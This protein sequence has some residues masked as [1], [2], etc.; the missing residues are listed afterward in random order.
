MPWFR[1]FLGPSPRP[2]RPAALVP[3]W[4]SVDGVAGFL[5]DEAPVLDL[6][7]PQA[8]LV[9][10]VPTEGGRNVT[11]VASP[12]RE[13]NMLSVWV[14]GVPALDVSVDGRRVDGAFTR[15]APDDTAWT[16][17]YLQCTRVR[18][19]RRADAERHA[20]ADRGRGGAR[21]R[22]ARAAGHLRPHAAPRVAVP[23]SG[24]RPDRRPPDVYVLSFLKGG[25]HASSWGQTP[26]S[27]CAA[28]IL[29]GALWMATAGTRSGSGAPA[30][31]R[32]RRAV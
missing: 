18:R 27:P 28:L 22:A 1:Q 13:G 16:L 23:D 30:R 19:H 12:G 8:A 25:R 31:P 10:V 24:G 32:P 7:A 2:G 15:R 14:N 4:S 11:F 20:A 26:L 5:H 17:E 6:P 21:T 3:P 9:R 29:L